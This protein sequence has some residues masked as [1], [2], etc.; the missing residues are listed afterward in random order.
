MD[1][2]WQK[3]MRITTKIKA[4]YQSL[5]Q[6][7]ILIVYLCIM[8]E[9]Q[10]LNWR[11]ATKKY[12]SKIISQEHIDT[13]L[14]AIRLAPTSLGLQAFKV[15]VI[16]KN[17]ALREQ[18]LPI[19][20]NQTQ[21]SDASHLLVFA[22]YTEVHNQHIQNYLSNIANTRQI[23]IEALDGFKK[24][25]HGFTSNKNEQQT[26]EWASR[27]CYIALGMAMDTAAKLKIDTTPMEG[28]NHEGLDQVL[29]LKER[30]L[31]SS[32]ILA[33]GYRDEENDKLA[34]LP[35]V[36]KPHTELFEMM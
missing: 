19:A 20:Y 13:I 25:I 9:I 36:R 21:I 8:E 22:A 16:D 32:V 35:K 12:S 34:S 10:H 17:S 23:P 26:A 18:L 27:Q 14:E 5:K 31:T 6:P 24:S 7:I 2:K 15:F 30:N 11:Y 1:Q 28:F 4:I 33:L 29:G 3:S